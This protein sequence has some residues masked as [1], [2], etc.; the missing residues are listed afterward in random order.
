MKGWERK[1]RGE[2]R[3]GWEGKERGVKGLKEGEGR[4]RIGKEKRKR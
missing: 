1:G 3:E 4:E 2:G